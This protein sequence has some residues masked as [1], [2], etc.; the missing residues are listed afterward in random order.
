M[1]FLVVAGAETDVKDSKNLLDIPLGSARVSYWCVFLKDSSQLVVVT[2]R[3]LQLWALADP[4][5]GREC[6]E[7]RLVW[8]LPSAN[9]EI[10]Y[11]PTD[12]GSRKIVSAKM[13]RHG[14]E[15]LL[16]LHPSQ[17]YRRGKKLDMGSSQSS[18]V[19]TFPRSKWDTNPMTAKERVD[20][21]MRGAVDL[22][23]DSE[24]DS[25]C[26]KAVIGYLR[27]LIRPSLENPESCIVTLCRIWTLEERDQFRD[28]MKELLST[29]GPVTWIPELQRHVKG[30]SDPLALSI[31]FKIA[32]THPTV[33]GMVMV[34]VDYCVHHANE[35]KNLSH[36]MPIFGSLREFMELYPE[37]AFKSMSRI[38][39]IPV[40]DRSYIIDN[41]IIVRPP[42]FRLWWEAKT[43][44][45]LYKITQPIMQFQ[46]SPKTDPLNGNFTQQVF[47]AS[48]QAL[49]SYR[50]APP[51]MHHAEPGINTKSTWWENVRDRPTVQCYDFNLDFFDNPAIAA[52]V[53][54]KW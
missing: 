50:H 29:E 32:K 46:V 45:P 9:S 22:F 23:V 8:A 44:E 19:I 6:C 26:R 47:M 1:T 10:K 30:E 48:F 42:T 49:W 38:T 20:Q 13:D 18:Q 41:H 37:Q 33:I 21:G 43:T 31:L 51:S 2:A 53:A 24:R 39:F 17:W 15:F 16:E 35:D 40:M 3:Y 25:A 52:L 14:R 34:I 7:L 11:L 5:I 4:A 28:I 54:Y 27:T 12:I 36:L